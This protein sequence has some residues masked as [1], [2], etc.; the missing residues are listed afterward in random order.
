METVDAIVSVELYANDKPLEDQRI[1]KA[2]V[3]TKGYDYP[4]PTVIKYCCVGTG[5]ARTAD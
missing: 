3:D 5:L 4:E 2:E 1:L